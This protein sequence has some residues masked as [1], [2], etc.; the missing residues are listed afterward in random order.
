[1]PNH[2]EIIEAHWHL[3]IINEFTD[4]VMFWIQDIQT[5]QLCHMIL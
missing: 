2:N 1:M 5:K 3:E 4:Q